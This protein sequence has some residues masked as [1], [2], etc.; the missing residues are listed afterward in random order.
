MTAL[1][2]KTPQRSSFAVAR[3]GVWRELENVRNAAV[4][5]GSDGSY[6]KDK[7]RNSKVERL[8]RGVKGEEEKK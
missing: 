6:Q 3:E 7:E 5:R 2:S 4:A 8:G 1:K